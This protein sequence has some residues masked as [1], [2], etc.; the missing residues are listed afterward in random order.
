MSPDE[1]ALMQAHA[2]HWQAATARGSAI[3]FGL[4]ADPQGPFGIGIVDVDGEDQA[5]A[6]TDA[7]PVI[8]SGRGFR[9]DVWPMPF[10]VTTR[11][12]G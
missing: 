3:C 5:R 12:N 6:F 8:A 2:E 10:G 7:D 9:Y 4:V 11:P 1:A